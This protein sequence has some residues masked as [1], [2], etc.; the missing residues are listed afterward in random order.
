M[1]VE[2]WTHRE[3]HI[4]APVETAVRTLF[5]VSFLAVALALY[6]FFAM[7]LALL[8]QPAVSLHRVYLA[9][10]RLCMRVAG[11]QL[12][13]HGTDKL[14]PGQAYVVV[15]NHESGWDPPCLVAALPQL[16]L[17]FVVKRAVMNVPI[18]GWAMR[19]TGNVTV[20]RTHTQA[21]VERIHRGMQERDPAVSM[22]FFAEGTRSPDGD[23]RDFKSGAFATALTCGL[24]ILPIAIAGTFAMWPRGRLRLRPV[25]VVVEVGDPIPTQSF[26][27]DDRKVLR[28]QVQ[29][30]VVKLH[31]RGRESLRDWKDAF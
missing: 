5:G 23:V 31:A 29:E 1:P 19:R 17:R 18:F 4:P 21:D 3:L 22:L 16:C 10:A 28:D 6:S 27:F 13:V 15:V 20:V 26:H 14:E 7:L 30:V 11:T 9:Y 8:G 12:E 25:P 2:P 24:P